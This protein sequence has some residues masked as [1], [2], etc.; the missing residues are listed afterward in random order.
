VG[1][2]Q[3]KSKLYRMDPRI[4]TEALSRHGVDTPR[5]G[6]KR[7]EENMFSSFRHTTGRDEAGSL[8]FQSMLPGT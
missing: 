8:A 1:E 6:I 7:A 3:P 5:G 4:V 2:A